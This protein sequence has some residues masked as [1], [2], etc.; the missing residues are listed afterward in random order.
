MERIPGVVQRTILKASTNQYEKGVFV[1]PIYGF[2]GYK[3]V[4][5]MK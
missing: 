3:R 4:I 2:C 1:Y 5:T